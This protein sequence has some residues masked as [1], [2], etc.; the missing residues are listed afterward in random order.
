MYFMENHMSY[1]NVA[2]IASLV[3][4][5]AVLA[6]QAPAPP[7]Q[8]THVS[9]QIEKEIVA[10]RD[11]AWRAWFGNDKAIMER[12]YPSNFIGVGWGNDPWQDKAG[13]MAAS[14]G[15]QAAGGKLIKLDFPRTEIQLFGDVAVVRSLYSV[16]YEVDGKTFTQSGRA[17]EIFVRKKGYWEH[18]GWHLDSGS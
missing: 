5:P 6:A 12:T 14:A 13:E 4:L 8:I 3:S 11:T 16:E 9:P 10:A 18:P 17:T 7:Q 15:F 2:L 1:R